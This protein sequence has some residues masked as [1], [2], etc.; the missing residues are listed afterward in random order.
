MTIRG[1]CKLSM[2]NG[3]H[4]PIYYAI[5]KYSFD[6]IRCE[7]QSMHIIVVQNGKVMKVIDL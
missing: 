1:E 2:A 4:G 3:E 5:V 7:A 6:S